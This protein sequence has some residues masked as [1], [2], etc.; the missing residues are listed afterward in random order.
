MSTRNDRSAA[1]S[2]AFFTPRRLL[3]AAGTLALLAAMWYFSD[4]VAYLLTAWV[5]SMLGR[6]MM[7]FFQ[8]KICVGKYRMGPTGAA[9]LTIVAFFG[10]LIGLLMIFIPTISQQAANLANADYAAMSEKLRGPFTYLDQQAH[11]LGLLKPK[12]SLG[13]KLQEAGTSVVQSGVVGNVVGSFLSTA[14]NVLVAISSTAFILF[15]FLQ[16]RHLFVDIIHAV[17]PTE[18]EDKVRQVVA[19]SSDVLT[20]YFRGLLIQTL[21][22]ATMITTLLWVLGV[23]NALLI[24]I[25]GGLLN[26]VP[27]VGPI[28]G[29]FLGCFITFSSNANLDLGVLWPMLAKVAGTFGVVQVLDN[30][31]I[32]TIIFSKSVQ[33]HPLE[34]FIVTLMAAKIGGVAGMVLGIPVYT[35]IRVVLRT[36]FSKFKV[37]QRLTEHLDDTEEESR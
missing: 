29:L 30:L 11:A 33:A 23:P 6:P 17:V 1:T 16:E 14:S 27:Y 28:I 4:I 13:T 22:F 36:F 20:R 7:V 37:V 9:T 34:I 10:I 32:S 18:Q 31:V 5:L 25:F 15:F 19:E 24:G 8:R 26:I 21:A 35:V 12:E 3:Y 2:Q